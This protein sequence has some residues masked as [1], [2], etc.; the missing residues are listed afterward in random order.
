MDKVLL[1]SRPQVPSLNNAGGPK[2]WFSIFPPQLNWGIQHLSIYSNGDSLKMSHRWFWYTA[3]EA[4]PLSL[5]ST[6]LLHSSLRLCTALKSVTLGT[7]KSQPNDL[8]GIWQC[9]FN[10]L[11]KKGQKLTCISFCWNKHD[12]NKNLYTNGIRKAS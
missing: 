8:E 4:M 10:M 1:H 5:P 12:S 7:G 2:H 6:P 9:Y 11:K 3:L